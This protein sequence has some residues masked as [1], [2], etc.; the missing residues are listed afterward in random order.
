MYTYIYDDVHMYT[1]DN[2]LNKQVCC[3][4]P[5]RARID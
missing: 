3:L 4:R 5:M 2:R 1:C